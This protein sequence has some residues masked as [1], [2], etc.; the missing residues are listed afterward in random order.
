MQ[1]KQFWQI[2][3]LLFQKVLRNSRFFC[4]NFRKLLKRDIYL[5][6]ASCTQKHLDGLFRLCWS[7]H[8]TTIWWMVSP[9]TTIQFRHKSSGLRRNLGYL[10][11]LSKRCNNSVKSKREFF[12]FSLLYS[13]LTK[14]NLDYHHNSKNS[15]HFAPDSHVRGHIS[16]PFSGLYAPSS[17]ALADRLVPDP[18]LLLSL[19][20]VNRVVKFCQSR[21][22]RPIFWQYSKPFVWIRVYRKPRFGNLLKAERYSL[23]YCHNVGA[24]VCP[25][26]ISNN[27]KFHH[28]LNFTHHNLDFF[29]P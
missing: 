22:N 16:L 29:T 21:R 26:P 18:R 19:S 15:P 23:H 13:T 2:R 27:Y 24:F 10:P 25:Y 8:K 4:I 1:K 14:T 11:N 9:F 28:K 17:F 20:V 6:V 5:I 12:Y 7:S 3:E